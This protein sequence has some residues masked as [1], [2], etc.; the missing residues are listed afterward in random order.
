MEELQAVL[1]QSKYVL[2]LDYAVKMINIHERKLCGLPVVIQGETGVGKTCLLETLSKLWNLSS[3][4]HLSKIRTDIAEA[5][6]RFL[7]DFLSTA[8]DQNVVNKINEVLASLSDTDKGN[9]TVDLLEF[10]LN[11]SKRKET[12]MIIRRSVKMNM[13]IRRVLMSYCGDPIF[14]IVDPPEGIGPPGKK[15]SNLFNDVQSSTEV[16]PI[17]AHFRRS[18]YLCCLWFSCRLV[19][20]RGCCMPF[21]MDNCKICFTK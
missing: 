21:F 13:E 1:S 10:V 18:P 9:L 5:F 6:S 15:V 19:H 14:C 7:H 17:I 4:E 2:T 3:E 16:I 20:W 12:A 11:L 8:Q